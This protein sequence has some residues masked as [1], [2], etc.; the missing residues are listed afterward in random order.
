VGPAPVLVAGL[1][2]SLRAG[3]FN[4]ALLHIAERRMPAGS[5]LT[6]VP[7]RD[8]P[9]YDADVEAE[10]FPAPVLALREAVGRASAILIATPEYNY[11]VPGGLKNAIDWLSRSPDS[12][13][14]GKTAAIMGAGAR[15]GTVRAQAHLR[16]ILL[17]NG[18]HTVPRPEVLVMRAREQFDEHG[19]LLDERL[20][21][22]IDLLLAN[23]VDLTR[24][25]A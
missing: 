7:I 24:R 6:I 18:M 25:L 4:T 22:D 2:G 8:V 3:S 13:L 17:H 12:P 16:Q 23:L 11:S 20:A 5:T 19:E 10:G 14:T 21:G 9:L 1:S 15:A